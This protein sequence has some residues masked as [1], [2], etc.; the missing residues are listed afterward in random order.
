M[1]ARQNDQHD[2]HYLPIKWIVKISG[3]ACSDIWYAYNAVNG[4]VAIWVIVAYVQSSL[5]ATFFQEVFF[6]QF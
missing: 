4:T 6:I 5:K 1:K 2:S 3:R